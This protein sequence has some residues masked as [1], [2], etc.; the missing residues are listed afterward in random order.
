MDL[1]TQFSRR[2]PASQCHPKR[3][4]ESRPGVIFVEGTETSFGDAMVSV[5]HRE[6]KEYGYAFGWG[7]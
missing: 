7:G 3:H 2:P 4:R 1:W 6:R 5:Y